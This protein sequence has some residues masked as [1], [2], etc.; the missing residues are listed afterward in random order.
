[1]PPLIKASGVRVLGIDPGF[2]R[3]GIAVIET[4]GGTCSLVYSDCFET[5]AGT[6]HE[7][8]LLAIGQEVGRITKKYSVDNL[9]IEK[10]F[11]NSNQKTAMG[12]AE[13]RGVVLYEASRHGISVFEYAPLAIKMALTGFGRADK[14][15]ISFMVKQLLKQDFA[16]KKDDEFDAIAVA[17]THCAHR[18]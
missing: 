11:F 2:G 14:K 6:P 1:M 18:K 13:A 15:Q 4:R 9:A 17:L 8:R 12:V 7:E 3:L 10:L 5:H 16:A